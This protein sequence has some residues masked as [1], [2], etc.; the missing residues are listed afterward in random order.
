MEERI[1]GVLIGGIITLTAAVLGFLCIVLSMYFS[2]STCIYTASLL[3]LFP[4]NTFALVEL[5][6]LSQFTDL[7]YV[8]F[9]LS[10]AVLILSIMLILGRYIRTSAI[11]IIILE[12]VFFV[13]TGYIFALVPVFLGI[14]GAVIAI[15]SHWRELRSWK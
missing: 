2:Y 14:I 5:L 13:F 12:P 3:L 6:T 11:L 9:I 7:L 15:I 10:V 1:T 4:R 8:A